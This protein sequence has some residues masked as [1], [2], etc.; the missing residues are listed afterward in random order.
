MKKATIFLTSNLNPTLFQEYNMTVSISKSLLSAYLKSTIA[1]PTE[2]YRQ[3]AIYSGTPPTKEEFIEARNRGYLIGNASNLLS[4]ADL[5][6]WAIDIRNGHETCDL[7]AHV[8]LG[9]VPLDPIDGNQLQMEFS[10]NED[11][12][13]VEAAGTP[14]WFMLMMGTTQIANLSVSESVSCTCIGD[15]SDIG[16]GGDLE[17]LDQIIELNQ[18]YRL[19]DMTLNFI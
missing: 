5:N 3:I 14:T 2:G 1:G 8:Y 6:T 17:L 16:G 18:E 19:N 15:I 7:L 9:A 13:N 10:K 4:A 11:I 12:W